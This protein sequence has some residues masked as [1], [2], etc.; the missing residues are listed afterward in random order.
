MERI[1]GV[2]GLGIMGGAMSANLVAS[3]WR[4][5][6]YDPDPAARNAAKAAGVEVHDSL[7]T[8]VQIGRA[9]V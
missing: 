6:G 1:A 9:H 7:E 2:I 4:I 3:G 5:H 8:L